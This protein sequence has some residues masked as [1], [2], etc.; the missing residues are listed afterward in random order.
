MLQSRRIPGQKEHPGISLVNS[1]E[2][3]MLL[4]DLLFDPVGKITSLLFSIP[5]I[6]SQYQVGFSARSHLCVIFP[7]MKVVPG[8]C[9]NYCI[10]THPLVNFAHLLTALRFVHQLQTER[11]GGRSFSFTGPTV[12]NSLPFDIR[13]VTSTPSIK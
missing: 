9:Q 3:R 7:F 10:N 11:L 12:W 5:F 1:R 13:S 8:I 6:D 2:C 4:P